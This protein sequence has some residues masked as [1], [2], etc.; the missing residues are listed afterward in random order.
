MFG[1]DSRSGLSL[2]LRS[3]GSARLRRRPAGRRFQVAAEVLRLEERYMLSTAP[4]QIPPAQVTSAVP[5]SQIIWNGGPAMPGAPWN[6]SFPK[7]SADGAMKTITLTNNGPAMIYPFIRG[8]NR[9]MDPNATSTNKYYDPQDVVG[10]EYREY[11]GY[12]TSNGTF[13]GLP[14]G[15]S[16]TFQVPLVLWDGDNMYIA[17]DSAN[18]SANNDIYNYDPSAKVS[19]ATFTSQGSTEWITN[20]SNYPSGEAPTVVFYRSATPK[21]VL[22]AAPAQLVEWTFRDPYLMQFITDPL[23]TFPL[24][25]YDVSYVNNLIAPV[26]IEASSV[27]ITFGD[28]LS[29]MTPPTYYGSQDYGW[30]PTDLDTT[31]FE[32]PIAE[33]IAPKNAILGQY[34]G[35]QGWPTYYNP[36]ANDVV[37]PSGAN[38]FDNSPLT[39]GPPV[40]PP[41]VNTSP[42]D[43]TGNHWLLTS[44]GSDPIRIASLGATSSQGNTIHFA[45]N[46]AAQLQ[47]LKNY[48]DMNKPLDVVAS[49]K[50]YPA[51]TM[52]TGVDPTGLTVT[53][54][55]TH[56][57]TTNDG[58]YDFVR[59]VNDYAVT[60]ITNLWYSWANYYV[61][62]FPTDFSSTAMAQLNYY[63]PPG[64][65]TP[66]TQ[67]TNEITLTSVPSNALAVGMTV[68]AGS[69]IPAGTTILS[70]TDPDGNPIG[71]A[72]EIG[73]NIYL[74]RIPANATPGSQNYTFGAP[75]AIPLGSGDNFT[76]PYNLTFSGPLQATARLFAGSVYEAMVAEAPIVPTIY[77]PYS[78]QLVDNV[79]KFDAR[80]PGYDTPNTGPILV[81]EVRDVVKSILRGVWNFIAVP[82]QNNWY[83]NPATPTPGATTGGVPAKFNLLN[84][85]PYVYFVHKVE[86]M[87]GYAFSVDDDVAN[88]AAPGPVLAAS[89]T[90]GNPVYNHTPNNLQIAFGGIAGFGN[91]NPWFPTIPW[92]QITTT[93]TISKV[94]GTGPYA[95][96]YMVTFTGPLDPMDYL[97]LFNQINNP[98][99]GQTGAY[100]SAPG[101]IKSGTTLIF[102]GPNGA[103]LPQ[104]VL[105]QAPIA[106][107]KPNQTIPITITAGATPPLLGKPKPKHSPKPLP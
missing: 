9:G 10:K 72:D 83:P 86:D 38:L 99:P 48:I 16:I 60:D 62:L 47:M 85:D 90:P 25:N 71:S 106:T 77:L 100:I 58:V 27:P 39:V 8:E 20:T 76:K 64:Q 46:Y 54:S 74:S 41:T 51:G 22:A 61:G 50:D 55:N 35:G 92:G 87:A 97:K 75:S 36:N 68:N 7:P 42:Y 5:L 70:I 107:T 79:I 52:V 44:S 102:K 12:Q 3:S 24:I 37:I 98:G 82:N 30:N 11:I 94:G 18:L 45:A 40:A 19:I 14:N 17:T 88:P 103:N 29:T 65:T 84:L 78:A 2:R 80:L 73:D 13:V 89:S 63:I 56:K 104:I 34:F 91:P 15:A 69:G 57:G 6:M 31:A 26:S 49:L 4:N 67:P 81:G 105:S 66:T 43:P 93:A 101:Y 53:V 33:F 23:Q 96:D 95:N 21:T 28:R 59:P 32:G 1:S